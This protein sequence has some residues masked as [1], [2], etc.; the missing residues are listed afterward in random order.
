MKSIFGNGW[1]LPA[2]RH[3]TTGANWPGQP[4]RT[5]SIRAPDAM[6]LV[7]FLFVGRISIR[8]PEPERPL[9]KSRQSL[10]DSHPK[11]LKNTDC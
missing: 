3:L 1:F 5:D 11:L 10:L 6:A 7:P 9:I 2:L 4:S 8:R